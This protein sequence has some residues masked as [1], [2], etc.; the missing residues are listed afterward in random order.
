MK[1]ILIC[2]LVVLISG[3]QIDDYDKV[4]TQQFK[5][6]VKIIDIDPPK[7]FKVYLK[8]LDGNISDT[9]T[10]KHCS[11]WKNIQI[12]NVYEIEVSK[13]TKYKDGKLVSEHHNLP[14][15]CT[16]AKYAKVVKYPEVRQ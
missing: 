2:A 12:G 1:L 13:I 10:S 16:L 8:S 11:D 15:A 14:S 5:T 9:I 6:K 7:Y 4:V 3:C